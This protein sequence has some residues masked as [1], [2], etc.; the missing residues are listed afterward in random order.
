MADLELSQYVTHLAGL[1]DALD[2][3]RA[4]LNGESLDG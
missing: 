1:L 4:H 2:V 3:Q